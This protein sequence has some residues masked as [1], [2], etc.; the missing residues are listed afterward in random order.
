VF[1]DDSIMTIKFN[2]LGISYS[3]GSNTYFLGGDN[4]QKS[5]LYIHKFY[6]HTKKVSLYFRS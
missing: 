3:D 6:L 1:E 5:A 4:L 2:S